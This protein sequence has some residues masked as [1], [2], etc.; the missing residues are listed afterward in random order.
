MT[1]D[2]DIP[3][4]AQSIVP[5]RRFLK[6]IPP[7]DFSVPCSWTLVDEEGKFVADVNQAPKGYNIQKPDGTVITPFPESAL[8]MAVLMAHARAMY[9]ELYD[10]CVPQAKIGTAAFEIFKS[11]SEMMAEHV[12]GTPI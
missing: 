5:P 11:I 9:V 7:D 12:R 1:I 4:P 3:V 10:Q 2:F 8:A 6:I